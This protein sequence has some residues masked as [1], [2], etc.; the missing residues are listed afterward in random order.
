MVGDF[1]FRVTLIATILFGCSGCELGKNLHPISELTRSDVQVSYRVNPG[2]L[3]MIDVW[4][5]P[6]LSGQQFVRDDGSFT[7]SLVGDIFA[8]GKTLKEVG[9]LITQRLKE[10]V[11]GASVS[12]SVVKS[13]P[14]KYYLSG[15]FL[16]PGEY[17]SE[18]TI[19]LLQAIAAGGG[20]APFADESNII[21]IRKAQQGDA[22][23]KLNY[24]M[25]V[26]GRHPN[27]ELQNGDIIAVH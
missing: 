7:L 24:N 14:I 21:L 26:D 18:G 9:S 3:L 13:A 20:F 5:E 1:I 2:D 17:R 10:F 15:A 4:G 16:T 11:P 19:T 8:S 27:P 6:K 12:V 23:Y 22:R 25:L